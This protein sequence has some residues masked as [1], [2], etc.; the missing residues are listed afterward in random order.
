MPAG[1]PTVY[2]PENAER[3]RHCC[4]LGAGRPPLR[5]DVNPVVI[6][7]SLAEIAEIPLPSEAADD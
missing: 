7:G 3:A 5:G 2:S 6:G 4:R 1:R